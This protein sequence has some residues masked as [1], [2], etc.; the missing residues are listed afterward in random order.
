MLCV[1][2][3]VFFCFVVVRCE[4]FLDCCVLFVCRWLFV[5]G[6]C[7]WLFVA[8]GSSLRVVGWSLCL[9]C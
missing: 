3:S 7:C 2:L 5:V 1:V 8:L 4:L 6:V 9:V